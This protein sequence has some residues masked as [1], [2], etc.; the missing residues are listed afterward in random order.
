M[1]FLSRVWGNIYLK[2]NYNRVILKLNF[3]S[4]IQ[5]IRNQSSQY[6][7]QISFC[8]LLFKNL[9]K[10]TCSLDQCRG[11]T[12][13][14]KCTPVIGLPD[15]HVSE[16]KTELLKFDNILK[17]SQKLWSTVFTLE[18]TQQRI[19]RRQYCVYKLCC[20]LVSGSTRQAI[21]LFQPLSRK[22]LYCSICRGLTVNGRL[23]GVTTLTNAVWA[24]LG[25]NL[26]RP[27]NLD[28]PP[29]FWGYIPGC[30]DFF[31]HCPGIIAC[32]PE[33]CPSVPIPGEISRFPEQFWLCPETAFVRV[34]TP[35]GDS[36]LNIATSKIAPNPKS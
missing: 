14:W 27:G 21:N 4:W 8:P 25:L 28:H 35:R 33:K 10:E 11:N 15:W 5:H 31:L 26:S 9:F 2:Q 32:F 20:Q 13:Y 19:S 3:D 23:R 30:P 17:K 34:V 12:E 6:F 29:E 24:I 7:I 16:L 36:N 1:W 22:A 18:K